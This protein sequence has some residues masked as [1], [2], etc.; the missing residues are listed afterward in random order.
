MCI[1]I[2]VLLGQTKM[3]HKGRGLICGGVSGDGNGTLVT[4]SRTRTVKAVGF[5]SLDRPI[6]TI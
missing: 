6:L 3:Y 2:L 4:L 5:W 1:R